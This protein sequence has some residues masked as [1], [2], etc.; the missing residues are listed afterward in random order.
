[1]MGSSKS[2]FAR[3]LL[4]FLSLS[5][6]CHSFSTSIVRPTRGASPGSLCSRLSV[7]EDEDSLEHAAVFDDKDTAQVSRRNVCA[8]MAQFVGLSTAFLTANVENAV[9]KGSSQEE[10]DKI[11]LYKGYERLN[12]LL[13]NWV[14]ETTV[15]GISDNPYISA[16][17]CERTPLKVMDYLGYRNINDPLFRA[18]K[19]MR[20]LEN[21][22]PPDR[23]V[24]Y[25]EAI[26][27]WQEAAEEGN[28]MA[29][30]SSWGEANPG[31]GKDR[32]ELFIERAK[33]N[34]IDSRDSLA[35]VIDI[36]DIKKPA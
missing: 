30:I 31:G 23:V 3:S 35:T 28:G 11:K 8:Q 12:Y 6:S 18:D 20:R 26:E 9:A 19:T 33:K 2:T 25:L 34:V 32:V 5:R 4:V 22:V 21:L 27:K 1:M 10:D 36:L 13:D 7:A 29:Y 17:G 14:K 15:C 24:D 16:G